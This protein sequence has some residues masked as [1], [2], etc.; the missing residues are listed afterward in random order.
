VVLKGFERR[1]ENLVEG[2]FSRVFRSGLRP[3]EVGRRL[4]REMDSNRSVD[5]NGRVV[6]P[7]DFTVWLSPGD[8][9]RFAQMEQALVHELCEAARE[10]ARDEAYGFVGPV[11]VELTPWEKLRTGTFQIEPKMIEGSGGVGAGSLILPT[12]QRIVLGEQPVV[13]G[14]APEC[15]IQLNDTNVSRRHAEIR[16]RG[17]GYALADLGS[18]NGSRVNGVRVAEQVLQ[19]GDEVLIGNTR[20][21][22][23]AS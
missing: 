19:D 7:N 10:H 11:R 13:I 1:L 20:I 21:L 8:H 4:T 16:P 18:T 15:N 5:V 22:F 6:V 3:V 12:Q 17:T 2:T 14:R 9:E 23:E